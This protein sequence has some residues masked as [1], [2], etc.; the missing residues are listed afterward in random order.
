MSL[1]VMQEPLKVSPFHQL[2]SILFPAARTRSYERGTSNQES[3]FLHL[4]HTDILSYLY[5]TLLMAIK[6]LQ[7]IPAVQLYCGMP[8]R[9]LSFVIWTVILETFIVWHTRLMATRLRLVE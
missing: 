6:S 3:L 8:K 1:E 2:G 7:R 4:K 9:V 5:R